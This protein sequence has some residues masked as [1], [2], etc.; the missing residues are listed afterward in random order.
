ML[1][2]SIKQDCRPVSLNCDF[3]LAAINAFQKS[4]GSHTHIYGCFFHLSQ[5]LIKRIKKSC[6][7]RDW[8]DDEFSKAFRRTQAL[9]FLPPQ[10]VFEAFELIKSSCPKNFITIA[11]YFERTYLGKPLKASSR[12]KPR[13][14][15]SFWNLYSRVKSDL[16]RTNNQVESWHSKIQA[17]SRKHLTVLRC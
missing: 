16:P 12:A 17:E 10:L 2:K 8:L 3:E 15:I 5:A 6:T 11:N 13:F 9:A 1:K 14:P 4:Y 7:A